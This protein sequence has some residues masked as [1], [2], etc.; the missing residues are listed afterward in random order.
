MYLFPISLHQWG[1][2]EYLG[3]QNCYIIYLVSEIRWDSFSRSLFPCPSDRPL[4]FCFLSIPLIAGPTRMFPAHFCLFLEA[5]PSPA[6]SPR[7][8][9]SFSGEWRVW[10]GCLVHFWVLA[11]S[12][13]EILWTEVAETSV[14]LSQFHTR[15][16]KNFHN[17][18]FLS[19]LAPILRWHNNSFS[20]L[21]CLYL[22]CLSG[23]RNVTLTI[24]HPLRFLSN[25]INRKSSF[26]NYVTSKCTLC[27]QNSSCPYLASF[28]KTLFS[29]L[30]R[31]TPLFSPFL[32]CCSII[33]LQPSQISPPGASILSSDPPTSSSH[34]FFTFGF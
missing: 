18:T 17:Y 19:W 22:M 13:F 26:R 23:S 21:P 34:W 20:L 16:G 11:C 2:I 8:S 27:L 25:W 29:V 12:C 6:I 3:L 9:L 30:L 1:F 32:L 14:V 28:I 33:Y 24:C 5:V 4:L 31:S 10:S 7:K 15:S